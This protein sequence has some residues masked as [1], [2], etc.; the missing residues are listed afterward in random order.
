V[1]L[2]FIT[3]KG[4]STITV[5]KCLLERPRRSE[6]LANRITRVRIS[7]AILY[8]FIFIPITILN[9]LR[10]HVSLSVLVP[11]VLSYTLFVGNFHFQKDK[12]NFLFSQIGGF[13]L[14]SVT[15]TFTWLHFVFL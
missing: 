12:T 2:Y 1:R 14:I 15:K 11:N 6:K 3:T 10:P 13:P 7:G 5:R 4:R 8:M 9:E